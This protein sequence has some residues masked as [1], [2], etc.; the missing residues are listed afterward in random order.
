MLVGL[1][2]VF[3][4]G[5]SDLPVKFDKLFFSSWRIEEPALIDSI[6]T[7]FMLP[8]EGVQVIEFIDINENGIDRF[9]V[10][11][12]TPENK[13]QTKSSK[14]NAGEG[15][16]QVYALSEIEVPESVKRRA[17]NW[18]AGKNALKQA[19]ISDLETAKRWHENEKSSKSS[20]VVTFLTAILQNY[21]KNEFK[22]MLERDNK[23]VFKFYIVG[24]DEDSTTY[25]KPWDP[26]SQLPETLVDQMSGSEVMRA[27][28][29]NLKK[30][31]Q[32]ELVIMHRERRDTV[33]ISNGK[34]R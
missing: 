23:G 11:R 18:E 32:N 15:V 6:L 16:Y 21:K 24:F 20:L 13:R 2:A 1:W 29:E 14:A 22:L 5:Q 10:L 8:K 3:G 33:Y 28:F 12:L 9:D 26:D 25:K 31:F 34:G 30:E 19:T 7:E 27:F 4:Y 17:A